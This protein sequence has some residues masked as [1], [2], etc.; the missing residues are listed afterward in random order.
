VKFPV[1]SIGEATPKFRDIKILQ[2][3]DKAI[4]I[5]V[6]VDI[7]CLLDIQIKAMRVPV[8]IKQFVFRGELTAVLR[9]EVKEPPFFGG[10][11]IYFVDPPTIDF[12]FTGVADVADWKV[13]KNVLFSVLMKQINDMMTIPSRMIV[14]LLPDDEVGEADLKF[15]EPLGVLRVLLKSGE[16]LRAADIS[17]TGHRTSDPYVEIDLGQDRWKSKVVKKTCS[18]KWEHGNVHDFLIFDREQ[19]AS[20]LVYDEDRMSRDDLLGGAVGVSMKHFAKGG[21]VIQKTLDLMSGDDQQH[22]GTLSIETRYFGLSNHVPVDGISPAVARGPAQL[23]LAAKIL[24]AVKLPANGLPPYTVRVVVGNEHED[25]TKPSVPPKL[26]GKAAD[27]ELGEICKQLFKRNMSKQEISEVTGLMTDTLN[28]VLK[29]TSAECK[30]A[31]EAK[32]MTDAAV[33]PMFDHVLRILLPWTEGMTKAPV[34]VELHDKKGRLVGKPCIVNLSEIVGPGEISYVE[35]PFEVLPG[36]KLFFSLRTQ[37]L[38][39]S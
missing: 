15:P 19:R 13:I 20:F 6:H 33:N 3:D 10:V 23:M 14:D 35:K 7:H 32:K 2:R 4:V 8:G 22:A 37:W 18:P 16:N 28:L 34:A 17:I 30:H 11:E 36:S 1:V 26:A 39:V 5:Q 27:K 21:G 31:A 29:D 38:T 9:P 25:Q 12:D 24:H